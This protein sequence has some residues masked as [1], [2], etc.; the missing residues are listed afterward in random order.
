M[1]LILPLVPFA[2]PSAFFDALGVPESRVFPISTEPGRSAAASHVDLHVA[3]VAID[4]VQQ[5][6]TLRVSGNQTCQP[7]CGWSDKVMFFSLAPEAS[8]A[9]GLPP[10]ASVTLPPTSTEVNQTIQLP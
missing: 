9:A 6:A 1:L 8:E 5:T 7:A 10:S 4:S 3:V 2:I